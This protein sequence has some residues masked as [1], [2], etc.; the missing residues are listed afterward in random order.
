MRSLHNRCWAF[1]WTAAL[2]A[3]GATLDPGDSRGADLDTGFRVESKLVL[4]PVT[5]ID[6]CGA[7]VAGLNREAFTVTENGR[8]QNIA[9][10]NEDDAPVSIGIVF[11]ISGSMNA[12]LGPARA[13]LRAV[14]DDA[15]PADEAFIDTVSTRPGLHAGFTSDSVS[16]FNQF[17]SRNPAGDTALVDT[18]YSAVQQVRRGI[19]AR[20]ALIVIS[21]GM[22][23]HSRYSKAELMSRLTEADL[24]LYTI[25][26]GSSEAGKKPIEL[27]EESQGFVFMDELATGTGGIGFRVRTGPEIEKAARTIGHALRNRYNLG[28]VPDS[29]TPSGQWRR[30]NVKVAGQGL[31]VYARRGYRQD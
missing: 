15:N 19:H 14:L 24:Q 31:R 21:D 16:L 27:R 5:V 8:A 29:A 11:D 26:L 7:T 22:D 10:F 25:A 23:N 18:I 28:Y 20:K 6:R 9:S 17:I 12:V 2:S 3:G 4:V 13:A 30:I 1:L